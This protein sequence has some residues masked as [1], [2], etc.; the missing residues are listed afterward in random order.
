LTPSCPA[1]GAAQR[2]RASF[3]QKCGTDR[4]NPGAPPPDAGAPQSLRTSSRRL[5][6]ALGT[7]AVLLVINLGVAI[8]R[9]NIEQVR[10]VEGVLLVVALAIWFAT[11][12]WD[13]AS[14]DLRFEPE[15]SRVLV[16]GRIVLG[17]LLALAA[18]WVG[19]RLIHTVDQ[20]LMSDY[21]AQGQSFALA[22][23]DGS[24]LAPVLEETV[25]R[26]IVL[27]ALLGPLRRSGA[28]WT[29]SLMFATL[30]LTPLTIVH[31]TLL[32]LVCGYACLKTR[33]LWLPILVHGSY[34]AVVLSFAW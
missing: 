17:T 14:E 16:L 34:N 7:Y 4:S 19:S 24:L 11:R 27:G 29:S 12:R 18:A 25:F 2:E 22:L 32:G 31:H 33:G 3:C 26:G 21:R 5:W 1:C 28:L 6:A 23:L 15:S 20:E 8:S 30:H 10:W 13:S 9:P